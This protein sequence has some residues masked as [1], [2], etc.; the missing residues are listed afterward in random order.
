MRTKLEC[1]VGKPFGVHGQKKKAKD[2]GS[3]ARKVSARKA[4]SNEKK[5]G[6]RRAGGRQETKITLLLMKKVRTVS[7][8]GHPQTAL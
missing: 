6:S 2:E 5:L 7:G 8:G 1:G 3:R 4:R